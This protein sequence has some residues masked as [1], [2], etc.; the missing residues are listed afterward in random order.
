[1]ESYATELSEMVNEWVDEGDLTVDDLLTLL[2]NE[3][4]RIIEEFEDDD[5]DEEFQL[6]FEWDD[7]ECPCVGS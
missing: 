6:E 1:M 7:D 3:E 4:F 5:E 2:V